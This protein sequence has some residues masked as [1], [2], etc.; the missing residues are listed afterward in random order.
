MASQRVRFDIVVRELP[1]ALSAGFNVPAFGS[2]TNL[3]LGLGTSGAAPQ[4]A[5][6]DKQGV[7]SIFEF[8]CCD[9]DR[10]S[11][12]TA[13]FTLEVFHPEIDG[14]DIIASRQESNRRR[15]E[16]DC[17]PDYYRGIGSC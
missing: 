3:G 12:L 7:K 8:G 10:T 5:N 14:L 4:A 9:L 16:Y 15:E 13:Q 17:Y 2:E 6:K 1:P 11:V